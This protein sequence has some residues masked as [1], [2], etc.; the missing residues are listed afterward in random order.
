MKYAGLILLSFSMV[1]G[2]N[3]GCQSDSGSGV[4]DTVLQ[5]FG[6]QERPEGYV[7]NSDRVYARLDEVGKAE[8]QRLN[9]KH[10]FGEVKYDNSD[11]LH[12]QYYKEVK[13]YES[14]Y[15]VEA[16]PAARTAGGE[17][18]S[19][20]GYI[21]YRY[22]VYRSVGVTSKTLAASELATQATGDEGRET[23]RY[24]FNSGGHWQGGEGELVR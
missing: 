23:L 9:A 11:P 18:G 12:G 2:L 22:R 16:Q 21:D 6:L 3:L 14:Y 17:R 15:P 5:D 7:S 8:L 1:A 20:I 4:V 13:V 24:V 10:R 19:Y